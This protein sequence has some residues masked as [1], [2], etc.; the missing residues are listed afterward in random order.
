MAFDN[1]RRY[2]KRDMRYWGGHEDEMHETMTR[3][4]VK[5]DGRAG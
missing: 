2:P 5:K 1:C 3:A 4:G